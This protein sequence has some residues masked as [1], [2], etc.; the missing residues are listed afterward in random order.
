MTVLVEQL[1]L[2]TLK[3][4]RPIDFDK[5]DV[6]VDH[7]AAGAFVLEMPAD[8]RNWE[9]IQL[10]GSGSLV[11]FG[12]VFTWRDGVF[13]TPLLAEDWDFK[14]TNIDGQIT[15]TLVV[16]GSDMLAALA[17][18]ICYPNPAAAWSSQTVTTT[19][20]T[21]NAETVIKTIVSANAVTAADTV[22]RIPNLTVAS[23]LGR[24][25]SVTYKVVTPDPAATTGTQTAT[26]AQSLMDMIRA[27][28]LQAPMGARITLGAGALVFDVYEPRDLTEL[29]VFSASLG[30]LPE[31][32][33]SVTAPTGNAV[34]LQSK[35]TGSTFTQANGSGYTDPWRRVEV[36]S[37]QS[38]VDTAAD[39]TTAGNEALASGAGQVKIAVTVTDL[40]RLRFGAD[41]P[42]NSIQGYQVGDKVTLDLR[43]GVTYSDLIS[44]VQLVADTT[45]DTYTETV[46]PTIGVG[47]DSTD[48][49]IN[50][51][52]SA[53]LRALERALRGTATT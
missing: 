22:R 50:A 26:V 23:N 47:D 35:V 33:L 16:T 4:G 14:R 36:Y 12:L 28:D 18:R 44:K 46:T 30:N 43:D 40:P 39:I 25:A 15:E 52:V 45:G 7:D 2:G 27:V 11:P 6:T 41:D 8:A 3:R 9:M 31:A 10:D 24:G 21:G 34:L 51:K 29:A 20:Y 19:T 49:T 13:E 17:N 48:Q 5:I 38:S 42:T 53:R 37:D 32:T 1:D